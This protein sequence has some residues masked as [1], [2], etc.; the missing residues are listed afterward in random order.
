[1]QAPIYELR[2]HY[3]LTTHYAL[4]TTY[5]RH[6]CAALCALLRDVDPRVVGHEHRAGARLHPARV[7][8]ALRRGL[9]AALPLAA[10]AA[11][12]LTLAAAAGRAALL[13]R[14][15]LGVGVKV[16]GWG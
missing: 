2:T 4:R 13:L 9:A 10:L 16:K 5:Q 15:G 1:M 12:A 11:A 3:L 6:L 14:V 8:L 7:P